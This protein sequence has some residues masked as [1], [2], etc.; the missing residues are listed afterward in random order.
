ANFNTL[1][2]DGRGN[3]YQINYGF[4]MYPSY[5]ESLIDYVGVL[6]NGTYW[7]PNFYSG[8][9]KSNTNSYK[10][11]TAWLTGRYATDT[12]YGSK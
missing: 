8:A 10:D 5:R 7:N 9:W 2:D 6:K 12:S 3:Y 1:E 11:A 4:L